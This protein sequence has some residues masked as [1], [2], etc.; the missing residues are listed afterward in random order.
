[1][2]LERLR[3]LFAMLDGE[4]DS[5][6]VQSII[7]GLYSL[8][9]PRA[10]KL[11]A[12]FAAH[13]NPD[14]RHAVVLALGTNTDHAAIGLLICLSADATPLVRNWATFA[15]R[16]QLDVDTAEVRDALAARLD[17]SDEETRAETLLGLAI[18]RD[19]CRV[20]PDLRLDE[21]PG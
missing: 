11:A 10:D 12:R 6:V 19:H 13:S 17:D 20:V 1:M 5:G 18:R 7:A 15:L 9:D 14:F 4:R 21:T 8:Q 2:T 16:R 3:L